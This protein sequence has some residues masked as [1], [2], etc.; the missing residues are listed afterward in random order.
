MASCLSPRLVSALAIFLATLGPA[1]PVA[2]QSEQKIT[3]CQATGSTANPWVFT[4]IDA[5]DLAEHVARGDYRANSIADCPRAAVA[6]TSPPTVRPTPAATATLVRAVPT[7]AAT[8]TA[9]PPTATL[10][11]TA[12]AAPTS[13]TVAP[14]VDVAGAQ[15][16]PQPQVSTLPSS[17][18]EPDRPTLVLVLL[19]LFV[20]GYGLTRLNRGQG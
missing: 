7:S 9:L 17:G 3:I 6:A 2:A 18:G 10:A 14:T 13:S 5:R 20:A 8:A 19:G 12:T 4:T 11:A 16:T 1:L 15:A